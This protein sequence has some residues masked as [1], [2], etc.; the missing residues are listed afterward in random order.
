MK[1]RTEQNADKAE[2]P[3]PAR[4]KERKTEDKREP[5]AEEP[6]VKGVTT[7]PSSSKPKRSLCWSKTIEIIR[8]Q[9]PHPLSSFSL[10][11]HFTSRPRIIRKKKDESM[12]GDKEEIPNENSKKDQE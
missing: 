4:A 1:Q 8:L 11:H 9:E 3:L 10:H 12:V 6:S 7:V 2:K 5:T